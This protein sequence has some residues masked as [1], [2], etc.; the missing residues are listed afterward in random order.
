MAAP[1]SGKRTAEAGV[2][3]GRSTGAVTADHV[4]KSAV[5]KIFFD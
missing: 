2:A 1:V 3:A 5:T 4:R